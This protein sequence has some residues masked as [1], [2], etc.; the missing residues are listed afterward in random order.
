[1]S[2]CAASAGLRVGS[3]IDLRNGFDLDTRKGQTLAMKIILKQEPEVVYMAPL[4]G[5]WCNWSNSKS[6]EQRHT[7]RQKAL[8]MVRFCAQ[9]AVHQLARGRKFIIENPRDSAIWWTHAFKYLTEKS[10]VT[11]GNLDFKAFHINKN[12]SN[13]YLSR[14]TSLLHNFPAG[15][16][17]RYGVTLRAQ[18]V[19]NPATTRCN[20]P[21]KNTNR[22]IRIPFAPALRTCYAV[23]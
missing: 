14:P 15:A 7:D 12:V 19:T 6:D 16:S 4:S 9:V 23:S 13:G 2:Q 17:I 21:N 20:K 8:P 22:C 18:S 1:M 11:Y 5:P 3:P 10:G